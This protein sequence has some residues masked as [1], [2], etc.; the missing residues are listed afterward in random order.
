MAV[1]TP[2]PAQR[3]RW[4]FFQGLLPLDRSRIPIEMLAGLTL[5]ALAIPEVMGYTTI[6]G[7][8]VIT[9]LYTILLPV[10]VFAVF[11]SSR[12]LVVGAD[13]ATAAVMAAGLAGL[14]VSGTDQYVALAGL[15]ALMAAGFLLLARLVGLG[16]LADFLSRT[17]LVGFLT[18]VGVQVACGQVGGMLGIPSG[19]GVT[20]A[21]HTFD[22]TIGKLVS[23]LENIGD[24]S[25][26]TVAVSAGVLVVILGMKFVTGKIPGALIAVIGSIFISWHWNLAS[27]GVAI[28]G[29]V[30]GGLPTLGLPAVSWS[31]VI[32]LLGTAVSI[33]VLILAQSAATSR[34]YAAKYDD[35][36]DENVDLVGLGAASI[37]AGLSGTFVVNGSP[38]K[39]QMVDSAGGKS[40]L[41][42][43]TTGI[44]VAVVLLYLTVP[45][46]YMPKA[47][48]SSVVFLIGVELVDWRAMRNI[49]RIRPDEFVVAALTAAVVILVGVEQ[50][51][52]W[53]IVL[54]I[55]DHIR[56]S[57]RPTTAVIQ[58]V[59]GGP[60]WHS[61]PAAPSTRSLPGLV[62]YQFAA[63]LYY[64]NAS[65][66]AA[67]VQ[68]FVA[69]A[70]DD[71]I[72]WFCLD[73][74]AISDIDFTGA[75]TLKQIHG[76]L[77]EHGIKLVF[78]ELLP[79]VAAELDRFGIV[80]L[81]GADA[82]YPTVPAVHA[83][84]EDRPA[85]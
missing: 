50:G 7:M 67:A 84:F 2:A 29:P 61:V 74:A 6:A 78:T 45:L 35:A 70:G 19:T 4:P 44:I 73:A 53:A 59:E 11:G 21:S 38:T 81:V 58:P 15:L 79:E 16:F 60:G 30:P 71:P 63:G 5:A 68:G 27:H 46:Q 23:T 83:A 8:P 48:L 3:R 34:A 28:L 33:F 49:L 54:S 75:Q 77:D 17:V 52:I 24:I 51:I 47:V 14:A 40:Q 85:P 22:N 13:S 9:G 1:E 20:I 76:E 36:F 12:H 69:D 43:L 62:V 65:Y 31:D 56:R 55:I 72:A 41:A 37:A 66:F 26:T 82:L 80:E 25:W 64:A 10:L 57:Y 18:G 32:P 39:T 42:Q